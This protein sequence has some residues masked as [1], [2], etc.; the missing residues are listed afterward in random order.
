MAEEQGF[1]QARARLDEIVVQVRK[2]DTSLEQSLDL[3]EEGVRLANQCT[4]LVDHS[5]WRPLGEGQAEAGS[6]VAVDGGV[7]AGAEG[8]AAPEPAARGEANPAV[9]IH[10]ATAE[11]DGA[12]T[13]GTDPDAAQLDSDAQ[14]V[15]EYDDIFADED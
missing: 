5:E 8:D 6:E 7:V 14:A 12:D 4:E 10:D 13:A 15:D 3:L 1:A 9:A 11:P 2:K